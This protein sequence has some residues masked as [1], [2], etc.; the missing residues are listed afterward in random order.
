MICFSLLSARCLLVAKASFSS[1]CFLFICFALLSIYFDVDFCPFFSLFNPIWKWLLL[2]FLS[3]FFQIHRTQYK[4]IRSKMW[5]SHR[6]PTRLW[7]LKIIYIISSFMVSQEKW[8][9]NNEKKLQRNK[10]KSALNHPSWLVMRL[11]IVPSRK[12]IHIN[13]VTKVMRSKSHGIFQPKN[14]EPFSC[15]LCVCRAQ[16]SH[17]IT[18]LNGS[19]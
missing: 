11:A 2:F 7:D 3:F 19:Y 6:D 18:I 14:V 5:S 10:K 17:K 16:W 15:R 12:L 4:K 8:F 1:W 13:K 9:N